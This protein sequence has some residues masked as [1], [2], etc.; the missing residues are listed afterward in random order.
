MH[1]FLYS[2]ADGYEILNVGG[3][4][5]TSFHEFGNDYNKTL[6]DLSEKFESTYV[7][8][9][10]AIRDLAYPKHPSV[11]QSERSGKPGIMSGPD[12]AT[13]P[14]F[15][16]RPLRGQLEQATQ[17][18]VAKL[19]SGGDKSVFWLDT[20]GWLDLDVNNGEMADFFLDDT[21]TP[22]RYR[23]TEQGNQRVA[24]FLHMHVCRYLAAQEE[25]CAF[26]PHEV[27]QGEVFNEEEAMFDKYLE[28]EKERKLKKLFWGSDA[29]PTEE[30]TV[31]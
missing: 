5:Y 12:S 17:N 24:I 21:M 31:T 4:D 10:R 27:Y 22:A 15:I 30:A 13:I 20:S 2:V 23:L 26:L 8:L 7:S 9:I 19:Q 14:I 25:K 6:W 16:M 11:V 29:P 18:A 3:A 28:D 1:Q